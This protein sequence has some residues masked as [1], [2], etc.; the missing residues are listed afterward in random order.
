MNKKFFLIVTCL[1]LG[2]VLIVATTL[3]MTNS[4]NGNG[5]KIASQIENKG[6]TS[7]T[8]NKNEESEYELNNL[9]KK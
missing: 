9:G 3:I 8:S 6:Q 1:I 5:T 7:D 4:E 2:V